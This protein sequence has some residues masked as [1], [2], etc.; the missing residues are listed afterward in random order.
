MDNQTSEQPKLVNE[1]IECPY[2]GYQT[3]DKRDF[4]HERQRK[5]GADTRRCPECENQ[6]RVP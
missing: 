3:A 5:Y 1:V 4:P 2:C 6:V